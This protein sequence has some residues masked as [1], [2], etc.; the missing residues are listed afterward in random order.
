MLPFPLVLSFFIT[1]FCSLLSVIAEGNVQCAD[2]G[3]DWYTNVVGETPCKT[4]ERLRQICD[5]QYEVGRLNRNTPP[6]ICKRGHECCC[7]SISFGLSMLCLSCQQG[8]SHDPTGLDAVNGTYKT[9]LNNCSPVTN[10]SFTDDIQAAVCKNNIKIF[11]DMYDRIFWDD[12][13]W[14]Y[15]WTRERLS[16]DL[17]V[18]PGNTFTRCGF[19]SASD[20]SPTSPALNQTTVGSDSSTSGPSGP[21]GLPGSITSPSTTPSPALSSASS[22]SSTG[23]SGGAIAGIVI[24]SI[25]VLGL[26]AFFIYMWRKRRASQSAPEGPSVGRLF[27]PQQMVQNTRAGRQ[28]WES[29]GAGETIT[30]NSNRRVS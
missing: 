10:K 18:N 30:R 5:P 27:D 16:Q 11:D 12:G 1:V 26:W 24:G 25:I 9:Y 7:N 3:L 19:V 29:L 13:S 2:G 20:N 22:G 15:E 14:F 6:D 28:E 23:L 4:Y 8:F 17:A 21:P